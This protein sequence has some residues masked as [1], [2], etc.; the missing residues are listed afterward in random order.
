MTS[1]EQRPK[2]SADTSYEAG[3]YMLTGINGIGKST[4]V[5]T[6]SNDHPEVVPLHASHELRT[7]FNGIS[8]EELERLDA[9]DKLSRMVLHFTAIFD[10][11]AN[12][13]K[14]AMLD[15][16]LL[17]PIRT[18]EGVT[19]ENIWSDSYAPYT[20]SMVMLTADPTDV[21]DWR[22]EDELATGRKRNVNVDDIE[23]DQLANIAAFHDLREQGV[24][25][26]ASQIVQN[27]DGRI[28]ETRQSIEAIFRAQ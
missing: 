8:R 21:R 20:N 2:L 27:T 1:L 11:I 28:D 14:A 10:Q 13:G 19:Y 18:Q 25:P 17:V 4:I 7:L 5:D 9:A 24:F 23:T 12:D 26:Q 16:H 6:I 22:M 15:T 3:V